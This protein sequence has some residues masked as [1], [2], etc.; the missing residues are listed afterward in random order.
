MTVVDISDPTVI[1][2]APAL[3]ARAAFDRPLVVQ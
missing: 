2:V 1:D 3:S